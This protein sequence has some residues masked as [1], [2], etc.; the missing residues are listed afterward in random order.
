MSDSVRIY[1]FALNANSNT[2]KTFQ[3]FDIDWVGSVF[4]VEYFGETKT[5]RVVLQVF[6]DGNV[7]VVGAE[8]QYI[9]NSTYYI[10]N[11]WGEDVIVTMAN[12][13]FEVNIPSAGKIAYNNWFYDSDVL[14]KISTSAEEEEPTVTISDNLNRIIQAKSD[15]KTAIESKGVEV[16]DVTIDFYAE[17]IYEIEQGGGD[18]LIALPSTLTFNGWDTTAKVSGDFDMGQWDWSNIKDWSS[19]FYRQK[20]LT[21]LINFPTNIQPVNMSSMFGSC[22]NLT[23]VDLSGI[24]T[25]N[26]TDMGYM[27]SACQNL[28][29]IDLSSWDVIKVTNM[30]NMFSTCSNLTSI[31]DLSAWDTSNVTNLNYMF[32]SCSNLTS[33]DLSSWDTSNVTHMMCMFQKCSNL[34]EVRMGGDVSKL[35]SATSMFYNVNTTGT[36]YYNPAYDYSKIIAELPSKWTAV[37]ME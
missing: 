20:E 34:T 31:G 30:G 26:V 36:F 10:G 6:Q 13:W 8:T 12:G 3:Y 1:G 35:I 7:D 5:I 18:G 25:S 27:F 4:S 11:A 14:Y 24:D 15:I 33:V 21:S 16:G 9:D 28:T 29:S 22:N 17:K 23:S 37:P 2:D 32:E 19:M